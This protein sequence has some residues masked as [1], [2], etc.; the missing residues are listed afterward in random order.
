MSTNT[1]NENT[2]DSKVIHDDEAKLAISNLLK[3]GDSF[4]RLLM[5]FDIIT[6]TDT[7]RTMSIE[8]EIRLTALCDYYGIELSDAEQNFLIDHLTKI[9]KDR[10][11]IVLLKKDYLVTEARSS[12][13]AE[14]EKA[15]DGKV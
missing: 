5:L 8:D 15:F 1:T 14:L 2:N 3:F 10:R 13:I 9:K 7:V 12:F 6:G 11:R 4:C